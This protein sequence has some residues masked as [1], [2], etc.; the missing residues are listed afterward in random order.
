MIIKQNNLS[1]YI[2]LLSKRID[3]LESGG[4]PMAGTSDVASATIPINAGLS[5]VL[6]VTLS[7][8]NTDITASLKGT[9]EFSVYV[10]TDNDGDYEWP[11]GGSLSAG[12]KNMQLEWFHQLSYNQNNPGK[13]RIKVKLKNLDSGNHTYYLYVRWVYLTGASSSG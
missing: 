11:D 6:S 2:V 4:K 12:Q 3:R 9:P 8:Q 1:D 13:D 7:W 5:S 10:D